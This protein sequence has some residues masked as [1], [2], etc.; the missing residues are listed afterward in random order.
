MATKFLKRIWL[1]D[2]FASPSLSNAFN[3]VNRPSII[4]LVKSCDLFLTFACQ[5]PTGVLCI[6]EAAETI[7]EQLEFEPV[8]VE[9][10]GE[11]FKVINND[12][13]LKEK[14]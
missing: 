13:L 5:P 12:F 8:P 1:F 11:S 7:C 14:D 3:V 10:V 9:E 4:V 2:D 6:C